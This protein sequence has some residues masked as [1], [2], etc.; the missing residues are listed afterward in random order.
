MVKYCFELQLE[1]EERSESFDYVLEL[2][3]YQEDNIDTVFSADVK[4]A[5]LQNL[6]AQS[7]CKISSTKLGQMIGVW[8]DDIREGYRSTTMTLALTSLIGDQL[9]NLNDSGNQE[10]LSPLLPDLSSIEPM[11]GAL[12]ELIFQ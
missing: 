2:T 10:K 8:K 5:M 6:Q 3:A 11:H 12:P 9:T 4:A 7:S 1:G